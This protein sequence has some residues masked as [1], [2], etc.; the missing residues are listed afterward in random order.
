VKGTLCRYLQ[1]ND[2]SSET[3]FSRIVGDNEMLVAVKAA[4]AINI[5]SKQAMS[6]YVI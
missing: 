1:F 5:G 6:K 4:I 3:G 2:L